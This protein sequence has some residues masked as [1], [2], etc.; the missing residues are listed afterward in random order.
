M[1]GL[2]E[3]FQIVSIWNFVRMYRPIIGSRDKI[4]GSGDSCYHAY[5][6]PWVPLF[7]IFSLWRTATSVKI[8][9]YLKSINM[10]FVWIFS[11]DWY[12]NWPHWTFL[13]WDMVR[14]RIQGGVHMGDENFFFSNFFSCFLGK[15]TSDKTIPPKKIGVRRCRDAGSTPPKGYHLVFVKNIV[16]IITFFFNFKD[17]F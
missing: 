6:V 13:S 14:W 12:L 11:I 2:G 4:L 17:C 15:S 1:M 9:G 3:P 8:N 10:F 7:G 5:L 16:Y